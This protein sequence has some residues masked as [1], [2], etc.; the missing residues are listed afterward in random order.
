MAKKKEDRY[1]N[2]EELLEDLEA[3]R[4]GRSPMRAHKR[5]DISALE[6]L[7]E[8]G[9]VVEPQEDEEADEEAAA[10]ERYRKMVVTMSVATGVAVLIIIVL[11]LFLIF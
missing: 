11:I 9:S 10:I 6:Q 5:F 1:A 7:E 4:A 2:V 8:N 3:V